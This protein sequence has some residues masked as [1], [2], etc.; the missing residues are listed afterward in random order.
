M[1][2]VKVTD[3]STFSLTFPAAPNSAFAKYLRSSGSIALQLSKKQPAGGL[4]SALA[5]CGLSLNAPVTLGKTSGSLTIKSGL[6]GSVSFKAGMLF[7]PATDSFGDAVTVPA[8]QA[9]LAVGFAATVEA[10]VAEKSGDLQ[11]GLGAAS[12]GTFTNYRVFSA[13]ESVSNA[14]QAAL[15]GFLVPADLQDIGAMPAGAIATVDGAGSLKFSFQGSYPVFTNPLASLAIGPLKGFSANVGGSLSL[16][17]SGALTGGY[18]LRVRRL[19]GQK[20][21]LSYEKRRGSSLSVTA[22]AE[23]CAA[24]TVGGF[25]VIAALLKAVSKDPVVDKETFAQQTGLS[26]SE[27]E[28]IAAAVKAGIDRSLA[29][30]ISEA[31]EFSQASAAAFT[32]QVDLAALDDNGKAAVHAALS[33]DL[34]H[35]EGSEF[36]GITRIHSVFVTTRESKF[37][38]KVN[39]L[40]V[41]NFGSVIDLIKNGRLLVD[42]DTGAISILDK[43]TAT[44]IGFTSNNLAADGAKLRAVLA[45]GVTMTAAY[46]VG[47]A[48]PSGPDFT[49]AC[50]TF[51]SH[52]NTALANLE[53]YLQS[54]TAL[55]LLSA[56]NAAAK[57]KLVSGVSQRELG[58]STFLVQS[59]YQG[60]AFRAMFLTSAAQARSQGDYETVGRAALQSLLNPAD[61][62]D[63]E[64]L[65]PLVDTALWNKL[66]D[67]GAAPNVVTALGEVGITS[68]PAAEAIVGDVSLIV[69]WASAMT[70]MARAVE[71]LSEYLK[72][73]P[74]PDP[75]NDTFKKLRGSLDSAMASVAHDTQG[76]FGKP[77]GLLVMAEAS[78]LKEQTRATVVSPYLAFTA[79]RP[80][81]VSA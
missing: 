15:E 10:D 2:E 7:D 35:L 12:T 59:N 75:E 28:A 16:A 43:V 37:T 5:P 4:L 21:E 46:T 55:Q 56:T 54:V 66:V 79:A 30:S 29:A 9:Y 60:T 80:A 1:P 57:L 22:Q 19:D 73:N 20:F 40:G 68:Q 23:I 24:A 17:V 58:R 3:S 6:Q 64:R 18:Q 72:D 76:R 77:W 51:E 67:A 52:Q 61:P 25:D 48:V 81:E 39:L 27:I 74:K 62:A 41:F 44:R 70:G 78:G 47:G 36:A 38:F 14:L 42:G 8:G 50:W 11:F 34:T 53:H 32:Y 33:G 69:W 31:L 49:C 71:K 45:A 26:D 13:S 63:N 65:K